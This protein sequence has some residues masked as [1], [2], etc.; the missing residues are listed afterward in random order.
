MTVETVRRRAPDARPQQILEAALAEF[1]EQGLAGARIDDIA[2][3]AGIAKG[4]VYLYFAN[5]EELF[6][7][8]VRQTIV[9]RLDEMR[10]EF[11]HPG[12]GT[13]T[14]QLRAYLRAWWTSL[15]QPAFRTVYRLVVG[16]LHRFPDLLGFYLDEVASR[17]MALHAGVI[18]RGV[19]T[20]EFRP[21][22]THAAARIISSTFMTHAIWVSSPLPP[23]AVFGDL[24]EDAVFAQ[25]ETFALLALRADAG[26]RDGPDARPDGAPAR[27]PGDGLTPDAA[28]VPTA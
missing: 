24:G 11:G 18:A 13:A 14:E 12:D 19:E 22:D 6:Q 8:V 21:V 25:L 27:A 9:A 15:R 4:T 28:G 17:A 3:R 2:R 10:R 1:G 5:K 20:G 23:P 26:A 7:G 16:E